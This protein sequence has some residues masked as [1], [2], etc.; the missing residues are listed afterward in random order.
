MPTLHIKHAVPSPQVL[1]FLETMLGDE[2]RFS[3]Y[4]NL[5]RLSR[6]PGLMSRLEQLTDASRAQAI[7]GLRFASLWTTV[8]RIQEKEFYDAV[9]DTNTGRHQHRPVGGKHLK[10]SSFKATSLGES[11]VWAVICLVS[12][13]MQVIYSCPVMRTHGVLSRC[14]FVQMLYVCM[15]DSAEF[16]IDRAIYFL[17][18]DDFSIFPYY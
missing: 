14:V 7:I 13:Q 11:R 6:D 16:R 3:R 9:V 4:P 15:T 5:L 18:T 10:K 8:P 1:N 17:M 12:L 2:G